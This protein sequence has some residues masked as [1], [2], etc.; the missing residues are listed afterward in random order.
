MSLQQ[1]IP[2]FFVYGEPARQLDVGFFHVET[3]MQR[4]QV[5]QGQVQPHQHAQ[6]GQII[7]WTCGGGEYYV[8]GQVLHFSAPTLCF[9]PSGT[10]HGFHVDPDT[11][12]A[13][14]V[15]VGNPVLADIA[16]ETGCDLAHPLCLQ[17][18]AEAQD[19]QQLIALMGLIAAE[20]QGTGSY[21]PEI[22]RA[23]TLATCLLMGRLAAG[24]V[25]RPGS[26]AR[27]LA[28]RLRGL[29]DRH[30]REDWQIDDYC[31]QLGTTPYLLN[32]AAKDMFA[33]TTKELLLERRLLEA[34]RL[35]AYTER[36]LDEIAFDIGMTD[37][38]YFC[39]FFRRRT[40]VTA[41]Q[42]RRARRGSSGD[43][44]SEL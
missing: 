21:R 41:G 9:M 44:A 2:E 20:A 26:G 14:V 13:L 25:R 38:A 23:L 29:I 15:S 24:Q 27:E 12:D 4:R 10:V 37:S 18:A 31:G 3:V 33:M 30:F 22:L 42:W 35:L 7:L 11:T 16:R 39:R 5:H 34:K 40:G 36:T 32:R 8:E 19:W 1:T 28:V 6:M 17:G 43:E